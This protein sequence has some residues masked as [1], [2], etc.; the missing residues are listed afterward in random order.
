[1]VNRKAQKVQPPSDRASTWEQLKS[2]LPDVDEVRGPSNPHTSNVLDTFKASP[3]ALLHIPNDKSLPSP[4]AY[5]SAHNSQT[6]YTT[7]PRLS[8]TKLLTDAYC[9]LQ[10]YYE[11]YAGLP[12]MPTTRRM[13]SGTRYH[14]KLE[15]HTHVMKDVTTIKGL[16]REK[17]G[18]L[19][20]EMR[21]ILTSNPDA[22]NLALNWFEHTVV[23]LLSIA[24]NKL[25]R[26]V[27]LHGFLDLETGSLVTEKKD[28]SRAILVNGIAD[29]IALKPI[30]DKA[31][32]EPNDLD[33][34]TSQIDDMTITKQTVDISAEL[35]SAKV[36]MTEL[37]KDHELHAAD[38]KT[39]A[40]NDLPRQKLVIRSARVQC[41]YY[42][43]FLRNLATSA[44]FAFE[45]CLENARRRSLDV[46][47]HISIAYATELLLADFENTVI[48]FIRLAK[49]EPLGFKPF[50]E[51]SHTSGGDYT[52][53]L[54][55]NEEEF[56]E[57]LRKTNGELPDLSGLDVLSLFRPWKTPLTIQYFAARS[58]QAFHLFEPFKASSVSVEYHNATSGTLIER[59]HYAFSEEML[60]RS[61]AKASSFWSGRRKPEETHDRA[62]CYLCDY[63]ERCPAINVEGHKIGDRIS[64]LLDKC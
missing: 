1:M 13:V 37:A 51:L 42:S 56:R 50:D 7:Q 38:V 54:F 55:L 35:V 29:I 40:K 19:S 12:K 4:F 25:S 34:L 47:E 58:T 61:A 22:F 63:K 52:M 28:L 31:M 33:H 32:P 26:E 8:V 21:S 36:A 62:M 46:N 53:A 9:E 11:V 43:Q 2:L 18:Q 59:K 60:E 27:Y 39:R 17:L 6:D 64:Q 16:L 24:K 10:K 23:R 15:E 20:P 45:S 41:M 44:E 3:D 57:I 14:A 30:A 49:G 48:D 5:H